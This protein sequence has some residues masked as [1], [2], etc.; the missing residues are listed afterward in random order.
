MSAPY[1]G[2]CLCGAVKYEVDAFNPRI[3]HC[4][5]SM[6]RKFHGAAFS[7]Y[8]EA[9]ASDFRW[10]QGEAELKSYTA[11]NG[12]TRRF[13]RH[14]GSS[15]TFAP[16]HKPDDIVEVALGT[17]DSN[18]DMSPDAHIYVGSKACWSEILDDLPQYVEGRKG[19]R[20][21]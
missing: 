10:V 19:S 9:N 6:C 20:L 21:K 7:T 3:G 15:M 1:R 16:S 14:C 8:G 12:T 11:D 2:Q 4:H 5:C 17:L 13:C 18:L